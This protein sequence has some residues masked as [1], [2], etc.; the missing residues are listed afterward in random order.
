MKSCP[1]CNHKLTAAPEVCPECGFVLITKG[2]K[3]LGDEDITRE[4]RSDRSAATL[5]EDYV[6][7][8]DSTPISDSTPSSDSASS[9]NSTIKQTNQDDDQVSTSSPTIQ[10]PASTND[11]DDDLSFEIANDVDIDGP[12]E[13]KIGP[14]DKT[15]SNED[16]TREIRSELPDS[17][18]LTLT[19]DFVSSSDS[20]IVQAKQDDDQDP[21]DS[22][23][24]KIPDV[25]W[26]TP[27][28]D[29][30]GADDDMD[31]QVADDDADDDLNFELADDDRESDEVATGPSGPTNR[32]SNETL[33]TDPMQTMSRPFDDKNNDKTLSQSTMR[34]KPDTVKPG[35]QA[36]TLTG[37]RLPTIVNPQA[38]LEAA[39]A[40]SKGLQSLIPPRT[41]A[42]KEQ[43]SD[44]SDY[45][46][47]K[48]IGS[49]AYG[50]VFRAKQVPLERS[51]AI[52]LL[53]SSDDDD[54]QQRIKNEFLREAQFTGR[55]E[56]PNI[57]P[58]HDI[59]LTVSPKGKVN[60]FY[61]MKEIRGTSWLEEIRNN[62][63]KENVRVFKNV[64][65]AIAF[66]H[67]Q[68]ILHCDLKPD[69]VMLGE[70]GEVLVVDW[71]QAVD[72]SVPNT[73]RP[74]GTPAY[75]SPEMAR[76]WID[77]YLDYKEESPSQS[78]VGIRSDV[79]LLGAL[80]F[81]IITGT[82][83]HCKSTREP[84]YEVIRKAAKN[85]VVDYPDTVNKNLMNIALRTLRATDDDHIE[86][87]G[88][89]LSAIAQYETRSLS[90]QLRQRAQQ[91][92]EQAKA[93]SDYDHF[94][95]ARFGF[96]E[97][98]EKWDGNEDAR[99]GLRDAKLRCAE[100]AL[101]DQNFD[102]GLDVLGETD[103]R[104]EAELRKQLTEGKQ[105]RDRRKRLVARLAIGLAGSILAGI[106]INAVMIN[107]NYKS[108]KAR[109]IAEEARDV[110]ET[111]E[112]RA[113]EKTAEL[114]KEI[115]P[116]QSQVGKLSDEKAQLVD[117]KNTLDEEKRKLATQTKT[118][119]EEK[120]QL[121]EQK[122][123]LT[124]EKGQLAAQTKLL[125]A[126]KGQLVEQKGQLVKQKKL[127]TEEKGQLTEEKESLTEAKQ[128]LEGQV[129]T[130]NES[131]KLLRYKGGL[132]QIATDLQAGDYRDAGKNLA[133]YQNQQD[134]EVGRL[135]LLAHPEI[136]SL[137]PAEPITSMSATADGKQVAI[138]F[139]D[140]I[141]IRSVDQL[142]Q[143]GNQI[144]LPNVTAVAISP[145]GSQLFAGKPGD[146][147]DSAGRIEV[148]DL[149]QPGEPKSIR[150]LP[151]QSAS[152]DLIEVSEAGNA[153]LSVGKTSALRQSSG[154]GL[155]EPL[156][157][158][159]DGQKEKVELV[160]SDG[161]NPKFDSASFSSDGQR[162]LLTNRAG[163]PRDQ[164][165]H[166][167]EQ[168]GTGYQRI[169]SS[170]IR[171]ISAA[172]FANDSSDEVIAGIQNANTGGYSLA[173]WRYATPSTTNRSQ[174]SDSVAIIAPL[175]SKVIYLR[176]QGDFLLATEE[177]RQTTIW[178]WRN[179]TSEK[180][181][182]QS[183]PAEFGFVTPGE[184]LKNCKVVTAAIGDQPEILSTDL[185]N[186][187][188]EF[189]QQSIGWTPED[190]PASVTAM[191]S[192]SAAEGSLEA[193]GNDYGMASVFRDRNVK[194]NPNADR[195]DSKNRVQWNI[196]AWQYQIASDDFVFA[197]SAEDYLY[198]YDRASGALERVLT[199]LARY[200]DGRERIVD[201]QVSDD[202][203]VA[204]VRTDS[205]LPKFLLWD[206]Q[207]DQV[208]REVDYGQQ[209]LFGTGSKKQL[210][211]LA[212][213]RDGKWVIGA[214][215]GVFGWPVDSGQLVRFTNNNAVAA[216]STAN[217]IVFVRN[218]QQVLVSWRNRITQFDL[219]RRQQVQSYSLPQISAA[220]VQD[221]LLD[222]IQDAGKTYILADE[223]QSGI[224]L[225]SLED[226][227]QVAEFEQA[228]YASFAATKDGLRAIAGGL[229][230][231]SKTHIEIWDPTEDFTQHVPLPSFN[232]PAL[233]RHFIGFAKVSLSPKHGILLQT[234]ERVR[235][236]VGRLWNS[237]SIDAN[238]LLGGKVPT[239]FGRLRV[240]AQ[241]TIKQVV[242]NEQQAATLASNQVM[243]W[244]LSENGVKPNGV[245]DVRATTMQLAPNSNTLAVGTGDNRCV[246]YDFSERKKLGEFEF[247]KQTRRRN[248]NGM[249]IR[250]KSNRHRSVD[251]HHRS[252][253]VEQR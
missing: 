11:D 38:A 225:L 178:D 64:T 204:L 50:T 101:E 10:V 102:L 154:Q 234:T 75:I 66:A 135:N 208:I 145:D 228:S 129:V 105:V 130:L 217:S 229:D 127:L 57:V 115:A 223:P 28:V 179:K 164:Q 21:I 147:Q 13:S 206:L 112:E 175:P 160:L 78:E 31:F 196:S 251:G 2:S 244:K 35:P 32:P 3:T 136:K 184:S 172:T 24:I 97:A 29:D 73:M 20:T 146:S 170:R 190:R 191:Y 39:A 68:N 216:R 63:L 230:Q 237:A 83:P 17:S 74:G 139:Q 215:V 55:L 240:L 177:N 187:R 171:G 91:L 131:S 174:G 173:R 233:D 189:H 159:I 72:L 96:E 199:K 231:N 253:E 90:I 134:W 98:L 183:R 59:G 80:L 227:K 114:Q 46:I 226:Q 103:G 37:Q 150:T 222:A 62:S 247:E 157:V 197:Q 232:D 252:F 192:Q 123:T 6:S 149:T 104:E 71:G 201:L 44:S 54:Q 30:D 181:K 9:S 16:T 214:K 205:N 236:S 124:E 151:A 141:E 224:L 167:F 122:K 120:G 48:R 58:I 142:D 12:D 108:G 182:G 52:K 1:Q 94:Q 213:S 203:R 210:P 242:S 77:I 42:Q 60:P 116:L 239:A 209:D 7:S 250:F 36:K 107:E 118:L 155:E 43:A 113:R 67:S 69:N 195:Y 18:A 212:L 163:L 106:L 33:L 168:T 92:L 169:A 156:M 95:R 188:P 81:E 14:G 186:Y 27:S 158:W 194:G 88:E 235:G 82:A 193:F 70:F 241:P 40:Y 246:L 110:A 79:Y 5:A 162:I 176:R 15:L 76:Y 148:F 221:N 202:G 34:Q 161:S 180:L 22:P 53:Q 65:N 143:P 8:S 211:K 51:V 93:E 45:Q 165:A 41:I 137:Y 126:E 248:R 152:I 49:G 89:L 61:V 84:P 166:V 125:T 85:H 200:L 238:L 119:T 132:T 243:F 25:P 19:D 121:V 23:T 128:N 117:D 198:Q 219:D 47:L 220:Q 109:V 100:L 4:I 133:Q 56:H 26:I 249:A 245:L 207:Q 86:T 111:D 138:V 153:V 99:K 144:D 87:T 185:A 140:R 218:S